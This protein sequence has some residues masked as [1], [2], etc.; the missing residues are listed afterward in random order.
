MIHEG[1]EI[2]LPELPPKPEPTPASQVAPVEGIKPTRTATTFEMQPECQGQDIEEIA[3]F[4]CDKGMCYYALTTELYQ[5]IEQE[6][7]EVDKILSGYIGI[8]ENAPQPEASQEEKQAHRARKKEW[9]NEAIKA[10]AIAFN[11]TK[12]APEKEVKTENEERLDRKIA[13]LERKK[14]IIEDVAVSLYINN[15]SLVALKDS[16]IDNIKKQ[17]YDYTELKKSLS[18]EV[19]SKNTQDTTDL[20]QSEVKER[21]GKDH[22]VREVYL[23][24]RN[25]FVYLR[26]DFLFTLNAFFEPLKRDITETM[27][28]ALAN[29]NITD[30][31]QL[32]LEDI[33]ANITKNIENPVIE[34]KW[35][36]WQPGEGDASGWKGAHY[37]LNQDGETLFA[38]TAEAQL[39]RWG[40]K[41]TTDGVDE[42]EFKQAKLDIGVKVSGQVSLAEA[43]AKI[44]TYLPYAV[45]Y[46]LSFTYKDGLNSMRHSFGYFRLYGNLDMSCFVG[47]KGGT[48]AQANVDLRSQAAGHTILLGADVN[49]DTHDTGVGMKAD[50]FAGIDVG[51]SLTGAIEWMHPDKAQSKG[52]STNETVV[53]TQK[54]EK[55]SEKKEEKGSSQF[56]SLAQVNSKGSVSFGAGAGVD[57]QLAL[58]RGKLTF[59]CHARLV[60]GGGGSGGF[61]TSVD[62][63]EV[64]ALV[65]VLLEGLQVVG[66]RV[67]ENMNEDMYKYITHASYVAFASKEII[68]DPI[69]ALHQAMTLGSAKINNYINET[70]D[71]EAEAKALAERILNEGVY[72]G[73]TLD[74][75]TPEAIG[76]MLDTLTQRSIWNLEEQQENAICKLLSEGVNSWRKFEEVLAHMSPNGQKLQ[77]DEALFESLEDLYDILDGSQQ[78]EFNAWIL[79]LASKLDNK[80]SE[81]PA[82]T[83]YKGARLI[84]KLETVKKQ[85]YAR[86][87]SRSSDHYV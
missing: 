84:A 52:E 74:K 12:S 37:I 75:L 44:E 73:I 65:K 81:I 57:F 53:K 69:N 34:T 49:M 64:W 31:K 2:I 42:D 35:D 86:V 63:K 51:G 30:F 36:R 33:K 4:T 80:V 55:E 5:E 28:E 46:E 40:Q 14:K 23:A 48:N 21:E 62:F 8:V 32:I 59:Y 82:Y 27:R 19:N 83:P 60:W 67:L 71:R 15:G 50:G 26:Y 43:S 22:H 41:A 85:Q 13:E 3:F 10:G 78:I 39:F 16:T 76:M 77:G 7:A 68:Q 72:A 20:G 58:T 47:T 45:G 56:T 17:I 54:E 18:S 61:G 29:G 11:G 9:L 87:R 24:T 79:H 1:D 38:T 6:A 70:N 66:Y 25:Q